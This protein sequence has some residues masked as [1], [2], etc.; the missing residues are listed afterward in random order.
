MVFIDALRQ[1][2]SPKIASRI[3]HTLLHLIDLIGKGDEV[4]MR[5]VRS[6]RHGRAKGGS[7]PIPEQNFYE[8]KLTMQG[9]L[10]MTWQLLVGNPS[11]TYGCFIGKKA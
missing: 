3:T 2:Q 9:W 7:G 5:W 11:R 6:G 10:V 8:Q 1:N 4:K